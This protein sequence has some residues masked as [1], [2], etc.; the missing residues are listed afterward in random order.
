METDYQ[1]LLA[2]LTEAQ[3]RRC[4]VCLGQGWV[5]RKVP[6]FNVYMLSLCPNCLG[7]REVRYIS[8]N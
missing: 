3:Y 4:S 8:H 6:F 2:W 7:E 1:T 5:P